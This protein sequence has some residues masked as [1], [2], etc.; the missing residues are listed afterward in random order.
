MKYSLIELLD[1][2]KEELQGFNSKLKI[3]LK[4]E[5]RFMAMYSFSG[6]NFF[7]CICCLFVLLITVA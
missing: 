2:P 3:S 6:N 4:K 1:T 7:K 5:I